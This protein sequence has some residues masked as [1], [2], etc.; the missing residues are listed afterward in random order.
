MAK[1]TVYFKDKAILTG[2][3]EKESIRL[4][5]HETND[6]SIDSLAVAPFHAVI[7]IQDDGCTIKNLNDDFLLLLNGTSIN[8]SSIKDSDTISMGKHQ[9]I[10]NT[11]DAVNRHFPHDNNTR[12]DR[13]AC[14]HAVDAPLTMGSFQ[15]LDG[16]NIGKIIPIKRGITP[17]GHSGNGMVA[18]S[19]RKNGYF[20]SILENIGTITLNEMPLNNAS[21]KLNHNDILV[22]NNRSLQFFLSRQWL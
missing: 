12:A 8:E 2:R 6:I 18:V 1:L 21:I 15:V 14:N 16:E 20:I 5:R 17:I 13:G 19:K 7:I 4:G 11:T 22:I 3:F 9:L 10:F